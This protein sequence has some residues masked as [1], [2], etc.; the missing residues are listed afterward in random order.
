MQIAQK[1]VVVT[2]AGSG[3]GRALTLQLLK[4]GAAVAGVDINPRALSETGQIA[5]VG[6]E[7]FRT[8]ALDITDLAPVDQ[9]PGQVISHF[10]T[11]DGLINNAGIIQPF[12]PVADLSMDEI[13]RVVNVNFWGTVYLTRAF[14]PHL[15]RR[16]QAHIVNVSSMGGFL[17]VPGQTLYGAA[18]AAVK[19]FTEGLYA[20]LRHTNVTVTV[21]FP[22]AVAT[23]I[24]ENSGLGKPK[25]GDGDVKFNPLPAARAAEIM[26]AA[27]EQNRFRVTVGQ[28]ATLLDLLY[29][30]NPRYATHFI[31]QKMKALRGSS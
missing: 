1:T 15:L 30:F 7:R 6:P 24:T 19:L 22:G 16:P 12:K 29:R 13:N 18:K 31:Q 17:P 28:D 2:G 3:I 25:T 27:I 26:I 9:L 20:E 21:V 8:F 4:R 5:G 14:L 10:G 11:V 23:S